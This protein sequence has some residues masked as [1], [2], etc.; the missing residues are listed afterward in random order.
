[1]SR[2][3][4]LHDDL[5][6]EIAG[7]LKYGAS[8]M[9]ERVDN[10]PEIEIKP[11]V[12]PVHPLDELASVYGMRGFEFKALQEAAMAELR[13]NELLQEAYR[14]FMIVAKLV[15]SNSLD[16]VRQHERTQAQERAKREDR[17]DHKVKE[18]QGRID[19]MWKSWNDVRDTIHVRWKRLGKSVVKLLEKDAA[20]ASMAPRDQSFMRELSAFNVLKIVD[21]R[22]VNFEWD[23]FIVMTI[24][25]INGVIYRLD[26]LPGGDFIK[27][28]TK[29]KLEDIAF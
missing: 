28:P 5:L 6:A 7:R 23:Y 13:D 17:Y 27:K 29:E 18:R 9:K 15:C 1:M 16:R 4:Y 2:E 25:E 22:V 20:L 24:E 14:K 8:N 12:Y 21:E 19:G 10:I 11:W 3:T 26:T